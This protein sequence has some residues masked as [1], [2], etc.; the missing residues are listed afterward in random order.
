MK[1]SRRRFFAAAAAGAVASLAAAKLAKPRQQTKPRK[2]GAGYQL[3]AH[4]RKY[5]RTAKV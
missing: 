5:Y 1:L 3:S 4:A 2:T